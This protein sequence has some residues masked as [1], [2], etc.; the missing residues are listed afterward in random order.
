MSDCDRLL[1]CKTCNSKTY[2]LWV[3][4]YAVETHCKT[5]AAGRRDATSSQFTS[6]AGRAFAF[7]IVGMVGIVGYL[8]FQ[9]GQH[10]IADLATQL[11]QE[12]SNRIQQQVQT[13]VDLPHNVNH[14]NT[15]ALQQGVINLTTATGS[16]QIWQQMVQFATLSNIYCGSEQGEYLGVARHQRGQSVFSEP[17]DQPI[18]A[19]FCDGAIGSTG[20]LFP[21]GTPV[22]RQW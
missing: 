20:V 14:L 6:A 22:N 10:A 13:Y 18:R 7:Q 19:S 2:R 12:L 1:Y 9:N 16:A 17:P 5:I 8:S 11:R 4:Y 3:G 15:G 21:G